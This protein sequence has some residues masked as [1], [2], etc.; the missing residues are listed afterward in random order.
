MNSSLVGFLPD[1]QASLVIGAQWGDEGK[2]KIVDSLSAHADCIV[3][4]QGGAN[5]GHT[6]VVDDHTEPYKLHII[7]S[8]IIRGRQCVIAEGVAVSTS[9]LVREIEGLERR[10]INVNGNL[11]VSL[12]ACAVMPY[13]VDLDV[14]RE[15]SGNGIGTTKKGIGPFYEDKERGL[16]ISLE[17]IL[18]AEH[19]Q[20]IRE[21]WKEIY[22]AKVR[23][24]IEL[25]KQYQP[26]EFSSI[27]SEVLKDI[28]ELEKRRV[29]RNTSELLYRILRKGQKV[30]FEGAQGVLLCKEHGTRPYVTKSH[31]CGRN[32]SFDAGILEDFLTDLY[33]IAVAKAY[34]TRVGDGPFPT[35]IFGDLA[36]FIRDKG[37]EYGTTTGRARRVG[38]LD[39]VGLRYSRGVARVNEWILTKGDVLS[40]LESL[41][42]ATKYR[43]DGEEVCDFNFSDGARV[44]Q[45]QPVYSEMAGFKQAATNGEVTKDFRRYVDRI[46]ELTDLPIR[47]VTHGAERNKFVL[48]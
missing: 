28:K 9:I 3:R 39:T 6:V 4:F 2:G 19:D 20:S 38:W 24:I 1:K 40:G 33:V 18:R 7:P 42:I 43:F 15:K 37:K 26:R 47:L 45:C 48:I 11:A 44:A 25:D 29:L 14:A 32:L 30:I 46:R 41:R 22:E 5:A 12:N 10:G 17:D 21:R 27:M 23:E 31:S 13:H 8:G 16:A 35:E 36:N 34:T